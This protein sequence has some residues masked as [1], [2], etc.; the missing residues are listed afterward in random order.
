M[1][2][3]LNANTRTPNTM[4]CVSLVIL[5]QEKNEVAAATVAGAAGG[6]AGSLGSCLQGFLQHEVS[7]I[8]SS[9]SCLYILSTLA[10]SKPSPREFGQ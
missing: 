2:S 1:P 7:M 4:F 9:H 8:Y 10:C 3:K 6:K 5:F